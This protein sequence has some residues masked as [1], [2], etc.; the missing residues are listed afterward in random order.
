[1]EQITSLT[2]KELRKIVRE[3][4]KHYNK[5]EIF[6]DEFHQYFKKKGYTDEQINL[7]WILIIARSGIVRWGVIPEADQLPPKKII[8]K[9]FIELIK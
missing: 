2:K 5:E 7:L 6:K 8:N 4:F 1:M 3:L 9:P